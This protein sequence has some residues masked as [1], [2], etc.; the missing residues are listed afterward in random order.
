[1]GKCAEAVARREKLNEEQ[2]K[3]TEAVQLVAGEREKLL[4]LAEATILQRVP[5]IADGPTW[6]PRLYFSADELQIFDALGWS[7]EVLRKEIG[8]CATLTRWQAE[9]GTAEARYA[10]QAAA[11]AASGELAKLGPA[12]EEQVAT[13]TRKLDGLRRTER[14]AVAAV[15]K[16]TAAV[17]ELRKLSPPRLKAERD[18]RLH[19]LGPLRQQIGEVEG[20]LAGVRAICGLTLDGVGLKEMGDARRYAET[21]GR[22]DL[23]RDATHGFVDRAGWERWTRELAAE[24]PV[25]EKRLADL[26][27]KLSAGVADADALLNHYVQ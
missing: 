10:A 2:A 4:G 25:L 16:Q 5:I 3:I 20:R 14:D 21:W 12:I 17:A 13:L 15:E 24:V 1:M 18:R 9:A 27:G 23:C 8:R 26:Q 7:K 11:D 19:E 22:G 6:Q